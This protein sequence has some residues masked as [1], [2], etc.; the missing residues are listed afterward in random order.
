MR[1]FFVGRSISD[2]FAIAGALICGT[3]TAAITIY[4]EPADTIF[5]IAKETAPLAGFAAGA[6]GL[7]A[8]ALPGV[9]VTTK[10]VGQLTLGGTCFGATGPVGLLAALAAVAGYVFGAGIGA[11]VEGGRNFMKNRRARTTQPTAG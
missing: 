2:G 5:K 7:L 3:A 9:R 11:C 1:S 4:V 6:S 8:N 10:E